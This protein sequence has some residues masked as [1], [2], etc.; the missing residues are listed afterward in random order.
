VSSVYIKFTLCCSCR[1]T[2]A[3][4]GHRR[5]S[6]CLQMVQYCIKSETDS[7]PLCPVHT[8]ETIDINSGELFHEFSL[9]PV[10]IGW[11]TVVSES[12]SR[13]LY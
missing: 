2:S 11:I 7:L 1:L 6:L 9:R 3:P 4:T 10:M 5:P 12:G 8:L 13:L